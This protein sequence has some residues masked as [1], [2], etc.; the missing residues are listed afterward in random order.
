MYFGYNP[1]G[2]RLSRAKGTELLIRDLNT[3]YVE[4]LTLKV[5]FTNQN[6]KSKKAY[7][8]SFDLVLGVYVG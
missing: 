6:R 1:L 2:A 4:K 7:P 5:L 8:G 3:L